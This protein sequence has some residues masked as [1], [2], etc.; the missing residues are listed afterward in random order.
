MVRYERQPCK[1]AAGLL[2][3]RIEDEQFLRHTRIPQE[4]K[5]QDR[6]EKSTLHAIAAKH[7]GSCQKTGWPACPCVKKKCQPTGI[8]KAAIRT[9]AIEYHRT[10]F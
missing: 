5:E 7:H 8:R 9:A 2:P 3:E 10:D 6:A 1:Y 4:R